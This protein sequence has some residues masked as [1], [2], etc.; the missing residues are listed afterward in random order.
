LVSHKIIFLFAIRAQRRYRS[1][2]N[3]LGASSHGL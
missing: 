1:N 3:A 2:T